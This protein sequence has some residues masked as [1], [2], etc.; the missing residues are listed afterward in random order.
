MAYS[1]ARL[2]NIA[3]LRATFTTKW[4]RL[5]YIKNERYGKYCD[6]YDYNKVQATFSQKRLHFQ[7][8]RTGKKQERSLYRSRNTIYKIVEANLGR[9]GKNKATFVTLTYRD[10]TKDLKYANKDIKQLMRR[11]RV[12]LGYSL[13]YIIVPER[14]KSGN[15]HYHGVFFNMPYIHVVKFKEE[16]WKNG[17]VDIQI[18]KKIRSVSAYLSKYLTKDTYLNIGLN[19]KSYFT[20]RGLYRPIIDYT[21][22]Y[23]QDIIEPLQVSITKKYIKTKFLCKN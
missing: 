3:R 10:G 18:P 6:T 15:I 2:V 7:K 5:Y 19:D 14:H 1:R 23:P 22:N 20:S 13:K 9:H 17:Y 12:F 11:T 8:N 21:D 4:K 16:L